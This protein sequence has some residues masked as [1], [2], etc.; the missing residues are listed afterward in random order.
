MNENLGEIQNLSDDFKLELTNAWQS[1]K[2]ETWTSYPQGT[3]E[4][5]NPIMK[6]QNEMITSQWLYTEPFACSYTNGDESEFAA[7]G[8]FLN[9]SY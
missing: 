1:S 5:Q 3:F 7:W 9:G 4:A 8:A 2:Y 6:T